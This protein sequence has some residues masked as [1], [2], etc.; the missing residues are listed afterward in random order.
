MNYSWLCALIAVFGG[1]TFGFPLLAAVLSRLLPSKADPGD[2]NATA[3]DIEILIPAYNES[4]TIERTLESLKNAAIAL[5]AAHSSARIKITVGIDGSTDSTPE[6]ARSF[7]KKTQNEA[8]YLVV[9][10]VDRGHNSGKWKTLYELVA[11]SS[12]RWCA[13]VD[14]GT[15]WPADFLTKISSRLLE[16]NAIGLAPGYGQDAQGKLERL[17]WWQERTLKT[18]EN[19]SGGPFSLHGATVIFKGH[20]LKKAF[21]EIGHRTWLNDD[22][23]LG[24][25]LRKYGRI[26]YLG[27]WLGVS[28]CGIRASTNE[29]KRRKRMLMGNVEWI[30]EL[31]PALCYQ[32][33]V[34]AVLALRRIM[35]VFWAY[36]ILLSMVFFTFTLELHWA[37]LVGAFSLVFLGA[38][39]NKRLRDAFLISLISPVLIIAPGNSTRWS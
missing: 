13:L 5:H 38:L 18:L 12:S 11:Q 36:N 23:V 1:L 8:A 10:V 3:L 15:L 4:D 21:L 29:L 28:D 22:V 16:S 7:A 6:L 39:A 27:S 37:W 9:N 35:R 25:T 14:A 32:S 26:E 17:V 2:R 30:R 34:V 20:E 19:L 33:P 24:L 31:F